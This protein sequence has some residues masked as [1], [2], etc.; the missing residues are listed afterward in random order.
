MS[1][2]CFFEWEELEAEIEMDEKLKKI[3]QWVV[4]DGG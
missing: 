3:L 1:T 2:I 4:G